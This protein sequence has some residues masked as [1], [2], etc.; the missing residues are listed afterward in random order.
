VDVFHWVG[1]KTVGFPMIIGGRLK[2]KAD[3]YRVALPPSAAYQLVQRGHHVVV[4]VGTVAEDREMECRARLFQFL[5][6]CLLY[7][8]LQ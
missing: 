4:E 3:E 7:K 1:S 8:G 2:V 5:P 6:F